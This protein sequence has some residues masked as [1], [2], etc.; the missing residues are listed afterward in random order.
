MQ[1]ILPKSCTDMKNGTPDEN[2]HKIDYKFS[3][4]KWPNT[5][6]TINFAGLNFCVW[7]HKNIF[8]AC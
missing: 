8:T 2:I 4:V 7:R 6:N 3:E 1:T 5:V